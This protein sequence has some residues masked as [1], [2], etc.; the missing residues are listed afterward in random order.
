MVQRAIAVMPALKTSQKL[1][2]NS[3]HIQC[4]QGIKM[5]F[6][7]HISP[8]ILVIISGIWQ[9]LEI[10]ILHL[11]DLVKPHVKGTLPNTR[12]SAINSL[13]AD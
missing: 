2:R 10:K 1:A 13:A 4:A 5:L 7:T 9:E 6:S 3:Q 12:L 11:F 8:T